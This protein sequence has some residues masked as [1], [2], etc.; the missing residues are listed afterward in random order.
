[1]FTHGHEVIPKMAPDAFAALGRGEI[2]YVK[3]VRSE[4]VA[5]FF[6]EITL[7]PGVELFAL[8]AADG[9]PLIVAANRTAAIASANEYKLHAVS[10]H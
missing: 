9:T 5:R 8:C 7:V 4:D 10:V 2:A 3:S 1:M 6:P